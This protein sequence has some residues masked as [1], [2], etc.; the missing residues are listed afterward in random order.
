MLKN[1]SKPSIIE[2]I[3]LLFF[4]SGFAALIYQVV[5]QRVLFATFGINIESVTVIVSVF[6]LGLGLGALAGAW[7]QKR[8]PGHL[9]ECFIG[10]E[11]AIGLFGLASIPLIHAAGE[12]APPGSLPA[13]IATVYALLAFPTMLMGATLPLLVT[14]LERYF[15]NLGKTVGKLYAFNTL[16]SALAAFLTVKLLFV[17]MGQQGTL[18]TAFLC[19]ALT[20]FLAW[21]IYRATRLHPV[22]ASLPSGETSAHGRLPFGVALLL[23]AIIGYASLSLEIL[24]FRMIG[25]MTAS[26]PQIFGL[27]LAIFLGGVAAGSLK[28]K[29]L[30][31][32]G[33]DLRHFIWNS[34]LS[35]LI[36]VYLSL[37]LIAAI[38]GLAGKQPAL[39]VAYIAIGLIAYYSGGIFPAL[40]HMGIIPRQGKQP[41]V[42]VAWM[43]F[44][45]IV[46]ATLGS[47]VTGFILLDL[48]SLQQNITIA[49]AVVLL[50]LA[51]LL[52]SLPGP[53]IRARALG[54]AVAVAALWAHPLLHVNVMEN[55][56][57]MSKETG[58]FKHIKENRSG[59]ITVEAMEGGDMIYGNGAY[60][61]RFNIDPLNDT[62]GIS[63]VYMLA[64]LHPNPERV[65]EIGLSGGASAKV[66]TLY[67]RMKQL[68]G[69]EINSG[70]AEVMHHYPLIYSALTHPKMTLVIDD[71]RR[72]LNRNPDEKFDAIVMNTTFYWRSNSTN[73]LSKEFLEICKRHLKPGG[74]MYY[75]TTG[76]RD[77]V[78][79][80]AHVFKHVTTYVNFV[81]AS[82]TPFN[83][84]YEQ[85]KKNL[86]A[87]YDDHGR[88]IFSQSPAHRAMLE[89][90]ANQKLPD[91]REELM[92]EKNLW[93]ITDDNM[94]S[95]YKIDHP[96]LSPQ[97]Y[98]SL[99]GK[100]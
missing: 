96:L 76:S 64:A 10:I 84:P 5:W 71:G 89:K 43:Y 55:L 40:C 52:L 23:S 18:V 54:L 30:S 65:L 66:H 22:A 32:E 4:I 26:L 11:I 38:A 17:V 34:L 46:G 98:F 58:P 44:G 73:L 28:A 92:Q 60:D 67:R 42:A 1:L 50:P 86:L 53:G 81:A 56:Q 48:F 45:N 47:L 88:Q 61:G 16:G 33:R 77:I 49:C 78:Y 74:I 94:A 63:R 21:R 36:L 93:L 97:T 51:A 3:P 82:D 80:A 37:P 75:N 27:M 31:E 25:F 62:N 12:L 99:W 57:G 70:Y 9:L 19:N 7:L 6:M 100:K 85:K 41:G 95:E 20:A 14:Y 91:L 90:L 13:L 35:L 87:F 59:I 24:W 83:L 15:S 39:F 68:I 29:R 72:W 8:F 2:T 69:I 79:T